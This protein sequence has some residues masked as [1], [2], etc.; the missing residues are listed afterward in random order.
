MFLIGRRRVGLLPPS[1]VEEIV[2]PF[3]TSIF[4]YQ[5]TYSRVPEGLNIRQDG[6]RTLYLA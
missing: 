4:I 3:E 1:S 2:I 6:M 5:S